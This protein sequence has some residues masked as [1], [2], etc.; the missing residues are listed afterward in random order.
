MQRLISLGEI[1]MRLT[2][3]QYLRFGQTGKFNI[4]YG[5]SEAN[6]LISAAGFGKAAGFVTV[7]PDN[8]FGKAS[9][10][11]LKLNSI[12]TDQVLLKGDRLGLYFLEKGA[13]NRS[14][15]VI[16]DRENSAFALAKREW[17]NW[18][19]ILKDCDWFHWS[20]ITPALSQNAADICLDAVETAEKLGITISA[21]LNYRGNLWKYDSDPGAVMSQLVAKSDV[22]LAGHYA[23]QQFFSFKKGTNQDL[24]KQLKAKFPKLKKIAIT[25]REEI[26]ASHHKWAASLFSGSSEYNSV[27]YDLYPIVDRVGTGDSF[28]GALIYGLQNYD[29]QKAL[30]FATAA[31]ALKH[32]VEGDINRVTKEEV[33]KLVEGDR[34]GRISR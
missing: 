2:C 15:K 18:E 30:D 19:E 28:M 25:N 16:Y 11:D 14:A 32:T 8:E 1:L 21:D 24:F 13:V 27:V 7:L 10:S 9:L 34:S 3:E 26:N 20:G 17:F 4:F 22:L 23:C 33:L 6:V 31:S 29:E 12:N 5:G